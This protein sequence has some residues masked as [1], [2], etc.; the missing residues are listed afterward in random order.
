MYLVPEDHCRQ[1]SFLENATNN[2]TIYTSSTCPY[3]TLAKQLLSSK[4]IT[5]NEIN[6]ASNP[7]RLAEMLVRSE[8]RTVP[9]IFIGDLHI[10]GYDDLL[11]LDRQ[12]KLDAML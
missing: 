7:A 2:V 11:K 10:G 6:V 5:P 3:C 4:R 8:R 9:Q 12:G 1:I